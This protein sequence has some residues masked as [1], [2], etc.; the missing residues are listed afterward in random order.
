MFAFNVFSG[1]KNDTI[2]KRTN[3]QIKFYIRFYNFYQLKIIYETICFSK[4]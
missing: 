3:V 2:K 4:F 1:T